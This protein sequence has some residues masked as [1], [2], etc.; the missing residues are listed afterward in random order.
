GRQTP[1]GV[2][3]LPSELNL[4]GLD[5]DSAALHRLLDYDTGLW[6]KEIAERE[7]HLGA[8]SGLPRPIVDAHQRLAE[9]LNGGLGRK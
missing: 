8:F 6:Q 3:P 4:E 7:G 1:I 5:L 2:L 9:A